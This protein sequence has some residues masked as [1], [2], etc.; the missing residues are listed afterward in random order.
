MTPPSEDHFRKLERAY[1]AAPINAYYSPTLRVSEG[2]AELVLDIERKMHHAADA[3]HGS[4]YFKALDDAAFFAANSLVEEVFVL[5]VS[6]TVYMLRPVSH[7]RLKARGRVTHRAG[8]LF[9]AESELEDQDGNQVARG[10]GTFTR[11]KIELTPDVGY[12]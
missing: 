8:R 9:F 4:V 10:S 11:G 1:G 3:V 12:E 2:E 5:T 6:F 7:G